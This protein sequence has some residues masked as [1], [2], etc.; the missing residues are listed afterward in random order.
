MQKLK[1]E[2]E[3]KVE[4]EIAKQNEQLTILKHNY[5]TQI[6]EQSVKI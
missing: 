5:E 6:Q 1:N 4:M 3:E 2:N